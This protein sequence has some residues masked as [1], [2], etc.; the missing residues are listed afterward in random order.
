MK[1]IDHESARKQL[2]EAYGESPVALG[3]ASNGGL[4]VVFATPS[5]STWTIVVA[6]PQGMSCPVAAGENWQPLRPTP[7]KP[8]DMGA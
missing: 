2:L 7:L 5:G 3:V 6:T 1:C 8:K 4:V